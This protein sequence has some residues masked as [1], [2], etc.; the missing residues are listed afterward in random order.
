MKF[1]T[2]MGKF[3]LTPEWC[4]IWIKN[5]YRKWDVRVIPNVELTQCRIVLDDGREV[6]PPIPIT[7]CEFQDLKGLK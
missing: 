7:K 4:V 3:F 2:T 6:I 1:Y 5:Q